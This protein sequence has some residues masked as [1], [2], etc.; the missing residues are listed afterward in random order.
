[1]EKR[2][3][4]NIVTSNQLESVIIVRIEMQ[5]LTRIGYQWGAMQNKHK[6]STG[7][8]FLLVNTYII[9]SSSTDGVYKLII[10][11]VGRSLLRL[12]CTEEKEARFEGKFGR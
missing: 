10:N 4:L 11:K 9:K 7:E 8:L 12:A 1:M 2:T 3:A 5:Y 6:S